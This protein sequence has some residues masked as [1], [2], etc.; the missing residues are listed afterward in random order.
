MAR[1]A[2]GDVQGCYDQLIQLIDKIGFNPS[3]DILYFVG[4]LVNRGPQSY[5][6]LKWI[7]KYQDSII[8]VLGNHDI[9]LLGRYARVLKADKDETISDILNAKD[10]KKLIDY[11]RARPLVFH[12]SNYI[13]CHAGVYP[14][15]NFNTL[16]Y[17]NTVI[18]NHLQ[19]NDYPIF[20]DS[21]FGNKPNKW[22]DN[23]DLMQ[24]MKFIINSSTRMRFLNTADYSLDYKYK[25]ELA[26]T[27][28]E[29]TPWFKAGF[30][31]SIN[32]TIIF[33]H[34]AALGFYH[35]NKVI[36][37]DTGC[38]WGNKLTAINLENFDLFQV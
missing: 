15:I 34:W 27:P 2:I 37:L 4:D 30:D 19:S 5:Q 38:V 23:L 28:L 22:S 33:G 7:Y 36:S 13:L 32:K 14:K 31:P 25:G 8:T 12:D 24:K 20:I 35:D 26:N 11:L 10:S 16:I 3:Q 9:Y 29:L 21:I 17:L 1:Y 6:V 18:S